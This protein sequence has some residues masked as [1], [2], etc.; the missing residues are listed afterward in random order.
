MT[1]E[2]K[3]PN[4]PCE[5]ISLAL[6]DFRKCLEDVNYKIDMRVCHA[7]GIYHCSICLVGAV[8]AQTFEVSQHSHISPSEYFG[9][10]QDK[11]DRDKLE[12]LDFFRRGEIRLG[13]RY[14]GR[15]PERS[16][17]FNKAVEL[18]HA[19]PPFNEDHP[20]IFIRNMD[21]IAYALDRAGY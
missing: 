4:K 3:L 7:P 18:G 1:F 14:M 6:S 21:D 17:A 12:A 9:K 11:S 15:E 13:I 8:L 2:S 5:L 16:E 20:E 10:E 19:L